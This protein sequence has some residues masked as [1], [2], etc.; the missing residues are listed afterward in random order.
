MW[1]TV[2]HI[3]CATENIN[4]LQTGVII[5]GMTAEIASM[6]D[7]AQGLREITIYG[8]DATQRQRAAIETRTILHRTHH[9]AVVHEHRPAGSAQC[10]IEQD[11][12]V[13]VGSPRPGDTVRTEKTE[14]VP[15]RGFPH[16]FADEHPQ[17][18]G[19]TRYCGVIAVNVI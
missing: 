11:R 13:G 3:A 4:H 7:T 18:T 16:P 14:F 6:N 17:A 19:M 10:R 12:V 2:F 1:K 9:V 8:V 5:V 15:G